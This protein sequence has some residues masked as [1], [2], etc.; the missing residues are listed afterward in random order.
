MGYGQRPV[1]VLRGC[2]SGA[3]SAAQ[4]TARWPLPDKPVLLVVADAPFPMPALARHRL[5][6][7]SASVTATIFVRYLAV[8]R[9]LGDPVVAL[10]QR[11]VARAARRLQSSLDR[12]VRTG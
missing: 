10:R 7:I 11:S 12:L 2:A 3:D 6:V 4:M 8:L 9:E 1:V 5:E